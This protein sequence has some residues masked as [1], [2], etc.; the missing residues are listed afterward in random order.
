[1]ELTRENIEEIVKE[2]IEKVTPTVTA[3]AFNKDSKILVKI[4][5]SS[6]VSI[7]RTR[8]MSE[9]MQRKITNDLHLRSGQVVVIPSVTGVFDVDIMVLSNEEDKK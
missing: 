4:V 9:W 5:L 2:T 1:M 6:G 8:E 7:E 3:T